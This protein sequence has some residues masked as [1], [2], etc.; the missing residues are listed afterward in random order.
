MINLDASSLTMED[1]YRLLKFEEH[2][3]D[4]ITSLLSLEPLTELEHQEVLKI[5]EVFRS[6][7]NAGKVSEGQVR[8]L[9]IAQ[10]LWFSGFYQPHIK[11]TLEEGIAQIDIKDEDTIIKGRMD[12]LAVSRLQSRRTITPFWILLIETKNS[13]IDALEGLPQ[14][15]TY[16]YKNIE[17]QA[18]VW[19]VTTNGMNYQF[20]YIQQGEHPTYQLLPELSLIR[21]EQTI[22]LLQVLKAIC[23]LCHQ[24]QPVA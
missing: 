4:S 21:P 1:V 24:P 14:L 11:I 12:I 3:N 13:T 22:Q 2:L 17:E 7:H 10:L 9:P 16:A 19:G 8:L 6:Y 18:A 5:R 23:K 15:L 20:V